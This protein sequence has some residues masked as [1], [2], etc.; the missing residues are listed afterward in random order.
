MKI[1]E[2][3]I[4]SPKNPNFANIGDYWDNEAVAKIVDLLH[5]YQ[6]LLPTNF[7][8]MRGIVRELGEM[9]IPLRLGT[10]SSKQ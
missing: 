8:E 6:N 7:S 1:K 5:E 4:G 9:K 3:H 2:V 10:K